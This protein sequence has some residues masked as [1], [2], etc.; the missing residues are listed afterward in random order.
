MP[1]A[2]PVPLNALRAIEIVARHGSLAP[3]AEELG[4]TPGAVSQH[5]RRAEERLGIELFDRTGTGLAPTPALHRVLPQLTDGFTAL[6]SSLA[7]LTGTNECVLTLSVGN[8]F[9]SRW[10]VWRI[11]KFN[12]LHP[13]VEVRLV[14]TGTLVDLAHSDVDCGI[15]YGHGEWP[16]VNAE[17]IGGSRYRPVCAPML[18]AQLKSPADL[19]NVPV[20]RDQSTMLSWDEWFATAGLSPAPKIEG[21]AYPDPAIAFDAAVSGQGVLLAV[22]QMAVDSV[23]DGR[24]AWPFEAAVDSETGYWLV[25]A[26]RRREPHKVRVF[27]DWLKAEIVDSAKGY[28]EQQRRGTHPWP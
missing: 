11:A 1:N 2:F 6:R 15:R 27:R 18:L 8:V 19:A 9:A 5:I 16:G 3:A 14:I 10:L 21:P 24:L 26:R 7:D 4:V 22:D 28:V 23:G 17:K 20:I 12:K 25:V 13:E